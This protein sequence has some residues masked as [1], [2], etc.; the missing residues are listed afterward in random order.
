MYSEDW[1][2]EDWKLEDWELDEVLGLRCVNLFIS[3]NL[4]ITR[5]AVVELVGRRFSWRSF[6]T[7]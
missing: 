3:V 1:K 5:A 2:L 6:T 7:M 4:F